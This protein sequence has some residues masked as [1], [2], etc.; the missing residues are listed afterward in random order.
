MGA[1]RARRARRGHVYRREAKSGGWTSWY[2]V[3]DVE[4]SED[5]RRHQ[6]SKAFG[7]RAEA[8]AWLAG[9]A[10]PTDDGPSLADWLG[11]WLGSRLGDLRASTRASY[12]GHAYKY[13]VPLLGDTPLGQVGVHEVE[14]LHA[15]LSAAGV[16]T[17]L[18]RRIHATLSSALSDA[19]RD[20][21]IGVNPCTRVRVPRGGRYQPVVWSA[22]QAAHFLA[23][24]ANDPLCALWRLALLLGLR[25][26]ELLGLRWSD[27]NS[28]AATLTVHTTRV[29]VGAQVVEG[30]PKSARGRRVLPLDPATAGMLAAHRHRQIEQTPHTWSL[31]QHVFTDQHG[32]PLAPRAVSRRF[33]DLVDQAGLPRIRFHDL[34]H[35]SATLGL[36]AGESLKEVSQRLGHSSIVVTADTYLSPPD[37]LARASTERLARTLDHDAR[38]RQEGAA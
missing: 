1:K 7:T 26:G 34:R 28:A 12:R 14:A 35:T 33:G 3:I 10:Q 22:E 6:K 23:C 4:R 11:Q 29:A 25:R 15:M 17:E 32:A 13:L 2:A 24:T 16:S 5:G 36:A 19:V 20:D 31:G 8:Y 9:M 37:R 38:R 18:A 30:P 21:L 27:I